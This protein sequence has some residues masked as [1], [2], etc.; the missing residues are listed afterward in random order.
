MINAL[1]ELLPLGLLFILGK[2]NATN[3]SQ[4]FNITLT[5]DKLNWE[6]K[7]RSLNCPLGLILNSSD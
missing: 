4:M 1:S 6:Q 5:M 7:G 3:T 2:I